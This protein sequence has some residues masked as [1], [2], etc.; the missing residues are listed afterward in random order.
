MFDIDL[1]AECL[2]QLVELRLS[3]TAGQQHWQKIK[4]SS[5]SFPSQQ[6]TKLRDSDS[7]RVSNDGAVLLLVSRVLEHQIVPDPRVSLAGLSLSEHRDGGS[8]VPPVITELYV[9]T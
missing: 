5:A 6:L 7:R 4:L 8:D 9:F 1:H 3:V 2:G